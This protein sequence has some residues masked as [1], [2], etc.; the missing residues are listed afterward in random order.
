MKNRRITET[1]EELRP[2]E[3]CLRSGAE[4]LSDPEL[5]AVIIR[6]GTKESTAEELARQLLY[7]DG[8]SIGLNRLM[9]FSAEELMSF[10]G[11]GKVKALQLLCIGELC[12]RMSRE[13][14]TASETFS[15]SF[16]AAQFYMQDLKGLSEE[17]VYIMLLDTKNGLIRSV[18]VSMGTVNCSAV[19]PR[20]I[21]ITALSMRAASFLLVHNHP[22]GDPEPSNED[23][24]FSRLLSSLGRMMNIPMRDSII[25]GD[26]RYISLLEKGLI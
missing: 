26:N 24:S 11:I 3:K 7:R 5:L 1:P 17:H 15:S 20:E 6:T 4:Y 8:N 18:P 25:I 23:I 16:S 2:Y 9:R 19:S 21:F 14:A 13:K 12:R 10:K 22:S